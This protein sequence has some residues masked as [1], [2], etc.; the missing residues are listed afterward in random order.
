MCL[1]EFDGKHGSVPAIGNLILDSSE[2]SV[3]ATKAGGSSNDGVV[4]KITP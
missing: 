4:F 1:C 3:R 2:K